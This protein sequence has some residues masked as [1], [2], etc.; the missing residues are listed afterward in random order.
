MAESISLK[1]SSRSSLGERVS[2][3]ATAASGARVAHA[4]TIAES[5][6]PR[7]ASAFR[8]MAKAIAACEI[9]PAPLPGKYVEHFAML[10]I[11]HQVELL[12]GYRQIGD[13]NSARDF[14]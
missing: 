4:P 10:I 8:R 12:H 3:H 7:Q 11:W 14:T 2:N 9:D 6:V 13:R 1:T 5:S